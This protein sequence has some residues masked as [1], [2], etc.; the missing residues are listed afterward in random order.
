MR[1]IPHKFLKAGSNNKKRKRGKPWWTEELTHLWN[2]FCESEK[3]WR[4]GSPGEKRNLKA[5]MKQHQSCFDRAV[6]RAKRSHWK[7]KQTELIGLFN[8]TN[9]KDFWKVIGHLGIGEERRKQIP[10]QMKC[11]NGYIYD[12]PT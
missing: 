7:A 12:D 1:A 10:L 2:I 4:K 8:K 9:S 5:Y 6:Q 11:E 3:K